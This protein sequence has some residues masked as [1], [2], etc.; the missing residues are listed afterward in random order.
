MSA[1]LLLYYLMA[2]MVGILGG[3][4][5]PINGAL[6]SRINST[7]VATFTFYGIAF[8]FISLACLATWDRGAFLA[9]RDAPRWYFIAGMISV[10]VVGSSTFLIP[11]IGAL[12]LFVVVLSLQL[13]ARAVIS[14]YGWLESPISPLTWIKVCGAALLIL[15]AV[16][17]VRN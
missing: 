9:L 6:A 14:H 4:H 10:V 7:L 1:Q 5:V 15:G 11:R 12:N 13:I 2:V 3:I 8:V 17:V 16:L